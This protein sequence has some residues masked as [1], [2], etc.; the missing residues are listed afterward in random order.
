MSFSSFAR[1][2]SL[3]PPAV[4][5]LFLLKVAPITSASVVIYRFSPEDRSKFLVQSGLEGVT[6]YCVA[7]RLAWIAPECQITAEMASWAHHWG[8]IHQGCVK[9]L[10]SS[11]TGRF[12]GLPFV[13]TSPHP[14]RLAPIFFCRSIFSD[15]LTYFKTKICPSR[16]AS[17]AG[18]FT[19]GNTF[20]RSATAQGLAGLFTWAALLITSHQVRVYYSD[21]TSSVYSGAVSIFVSLALYRTLD[22]ERALHTRLTFHGFC[23]RY[24]IF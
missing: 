24:E 13:G 11:N 16:C 21:V 1:C 18:N 5:T 4:S 3:F 9:C 20:I 12:L 10:I 15:L 22:E 19:Q 6:L 7:I 17:M 23:A 2:I 14:S 8:R